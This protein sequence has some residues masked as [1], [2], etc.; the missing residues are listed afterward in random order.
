MLWVLLVFI[1]TAVIFQKPRIL[2]KRVSGIYGVHLGV[3]DVVFLS[4]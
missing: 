3:P 4:V 2:V 1:Q